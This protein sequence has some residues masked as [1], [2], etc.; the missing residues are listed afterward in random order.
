MVNGKSLVDTVKD[1]LTPDVLQ[2]I[3][4]HTGETP[5]NTSRA[6]DGIVPTLLYGTA[7][8]ADSPGGESQLMNLIGQQAGDGN[9]LTNLPANSAAEMRQ[10]VL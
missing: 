3:S 2:K 6:I 10:R 1:Y 4:S 7:K 9:I 8:L 5:G